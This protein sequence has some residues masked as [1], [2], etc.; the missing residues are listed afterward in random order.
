M[1]DQGGQLQA[2]GQHGADHLAQAVVP[3]VGFDVRKALLGF[4]VGLV[5][6]PHRRLFVLE[7]RVFELQAVLV[8]FVDRHQHRVPIA[9]EQPPA[10][11]QQG[12]DSACPRFDMGQ[13]A[14]GADAGVD[15][16]EGACRQHVGGGIDVGLDILDRHRAALSQRP[17]LNQRSRGIVQAADLGT[18]AR[19]REGIGADVALQVDGVEPVDIAEQRQVEA[20]GF[21]KAFGVLDEQLDFVVLRGSVQRGTF[22]PAGAVELQ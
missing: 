12:R 18:K 2:V 21:G 4:D 8:V 17:C 9:Q 16:V 6:V 11:L 20:Y 7:I 15:Q 13:P 5:V 3:L 10:R 1:L 19:Q 22:I 14:E